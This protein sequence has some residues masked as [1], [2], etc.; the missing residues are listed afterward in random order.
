MLGVMENGVGDAVAVGVGDAVGVDVGVCVGLGV[1]V[2][3]AVGV[4]DIPPGE[5]IS[6]LVWI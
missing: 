4:G 5:K 3:E 1:G 6:I 2:P